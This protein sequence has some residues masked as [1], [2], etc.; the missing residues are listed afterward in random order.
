MKILS[1]G[2]SFSHDTMYL[3]PMIA[4]DLGIDG[5]FANLYIGGCT[6]G[7]HYINAIDDLPVYHY[8][9]N[10]GEEWKDRKRVRISEAIASEDWD[11][12]N[13]QHGSKDYNCYT[14]DIFY[15]RLPE[16]VSFVKKL[17]GK[18]T[19]IS[20]NMAWVADSEKEHHEMVS[21]YGNDQTKMYEAL[22]KLTQNLVASTKG[23]DIIS[24]TGIAIQT[25]RNLNFTNLT[26]DGFHL[27][28]DFGRYIAAL[29]FLKT[30]SDVD[31]TKVDWAPETIT[32]EE[33]NAAVHCASLAYDIFQ[34]NIDE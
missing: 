27:S 24:P 26:R 21:L 9:I 25:A 29:T 5:V 7:Y 10:S 13:I 19:H 17:A 2:N 3:L 31:I 22:V 34:K 15:K 32:V 14:Q 4:K 16:L 8:Y 33:K 11:W 18:K 28:Y 6:I 23:I 30:L 12:I 1:I 20:F